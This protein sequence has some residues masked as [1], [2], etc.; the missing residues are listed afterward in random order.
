[1]K[2][3]VKSRFLSVWKLYSKC[4]HGVSNW[5]LVNTSLAFSIQA[6][7][8]ACVT[9]FPILLNHKLLLIPVRI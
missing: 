5:T 9:I 6:K 1:M 2:H 3:I 4:A 8:K 7:I